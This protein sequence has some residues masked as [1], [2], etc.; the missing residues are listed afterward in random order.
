M[1]LKN[2]ECHFN[3]FFP[4]LINIRMLSRCVVMVAIDY[5][6]NIGFFS[7]NSI[8][9][10]FEHNIYIFFPNVLPIVVLQ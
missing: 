1:T 6:E 10:F 5:L 2:Q 7:K 4:A 8:T 3:F 9:N